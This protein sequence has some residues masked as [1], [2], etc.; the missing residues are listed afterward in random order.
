MGKA[1]EAGES[2]PT[3][4]DLDE[5]E[6]RMRWLAD[7]W[8]ERLADPVTAELVKAGKLV[9]S[10][11]VSSLLAAYPPTTKSSTGG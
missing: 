5:M 4:A 8:R 9:V 1:N 3:Q 2:D 11:M 7:Q 6:N 10:P